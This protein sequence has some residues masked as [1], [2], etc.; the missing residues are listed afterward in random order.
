MGT[1]NSCCTCHCGMLTA[2]LQSKATVRGKPEGTK[3][4]HSVVCPS[5]HVS[6]TLVCQTCFALLSHASTYVESK[7]L[8]K[9]LQ[10]KFDFRQD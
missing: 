2:F 4:L 6:A 8:P 9:E 1:R 5:V 10:I 3:G 7:L